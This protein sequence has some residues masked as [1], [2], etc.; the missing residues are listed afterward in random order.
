VKEISEGQKVLKD[1]DT[2]ILCKRGL[3]VYEKWMKERFK[4]F[5]C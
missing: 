1:K 5:T 2:S 3:G 4:F